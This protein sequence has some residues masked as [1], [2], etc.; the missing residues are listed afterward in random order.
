MKIN[1]LG[2]RILGL[3]LAGVMVMSTACGGLG[4][5]G[6][7]GEGS[8]GTKAGSNTPAAATAAKDGGTG[9][10]VG[11]ETAAAVDYSSNKISITAMSQGPDGNIITNYKDNGF[12]QE[13]A[14]RS[15]VSIDFTHPIYGNETT[16]FDL[17]VASGEYTD[18]IWSFGDQ[19]YKGGDDAGVEDGV[20][21]DLTPY[22][23]QYMPNYWN[24]IN[25]NEEAR[26]LAYTDSGRLVCLVALEYNAQDKKPEPQPSFAGMTV[27][28]DWLDALGMDVP[29]TY[30]D[31]TEMLKAFKEKYNCEQPLTLPSQGFWQLTQ[32]ASGFGALNTMQNNNGTVEYGPMTEGWKQYLTLMNQWYTDGLIGP[33][34]VTNDAFGM[35][36]AL[37]ISGGTG[38][39]FMVYTV[40]PVIEQGIEGGGD[41]VAVQLP[42]T[43]AGEVAQGGANDGKLAAKKI[44]V[45][46]HVKDENLPQILS[47]LD[48][49]Y[50]DEGILLQS[51]GVE[52]DTYTVDE[53]GKYVFTDKILNNPE[54]KTSALAIDAYLCPANLQLT[55]DWSREYATTP[56]DQLEM[57]ATWDKD[58]NALLMPSITMSADENSVYSK[59]MVDVETYMK[60]MTNNF[61]MG[62]TSIEDNWDT[63][64]QTMKD[65]G[66]EEAIAAQQAALDRY[67]SK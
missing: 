44:Y 10:A 22:V 61:I 43:K 46:T 45:S 26:R 4:S 36:T 24:L 48:Y 9:A 62:V 60:E 51:Y 25:A 58:G 29:V 50:S 21:R 11:G 1:R 65:M 5:G 67:M 63:Y 12:F 37:A 16:E 13:L 28:K 66:V 3:V 55:K 64:V 18:L 6:D 32:F 14:R 23:E 49:L 42:V 38:A 31:W 15:G 47:M 57:C 40:T 54:T 8:G 52:G 20:F 17:M 27:R 56:E 35:D 39:M 53:N 2:K 7:S 34:Y 30:D 19:A 41:F 59:K 33:E